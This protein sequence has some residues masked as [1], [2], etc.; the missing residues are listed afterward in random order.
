MNGVSLADALL[1]NMNKL[2]ILRAHCCFQTAT[3]LVAVDE[4]ESAMQMFDKAI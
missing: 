1:L 2:R 4:L 3:D